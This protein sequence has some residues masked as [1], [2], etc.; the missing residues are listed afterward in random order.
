MFF[1]VLGHFLTYPLFPPPFCGRVNEVVSGVR[2]MVVFKKGGYGGCSPG[3]KTGTR[4]HL[5]VSPGTKTGTRGRSHVPLERNTGTRAHSPKPPFC[6]TVLL[7][8]LDYGE[9]DQH[10]AV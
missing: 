8:P 10:P 3:T 4:V 5:D 2:N 7:F 9:V 6:E 1:D